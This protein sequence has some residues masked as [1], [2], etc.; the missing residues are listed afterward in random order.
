[1]KAK[2]DQERLRNL[3][4]AT[5]KTQGEIADELGMSRSTFALLCSNRKEYPHSQD[6]DT[7]KNIADFF[8]V[9]PKYLTGESDYMNA[10][11]FISTAEDKMFE[12][13]CIGDM[14]IKLGIVTPLDDKKYMQLSA[15]GDHNSVFIDNP[16]HVDMNEIEYS[17]FTAYLAEQIRS[18]CNNYARISVSH[19]IYGSHDFD[20]YS[21]ITPD[22]LQKADQ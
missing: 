14:L 11:H 9:D 3:W 5:G 15:E 7:I 17:M 13:R 21:D 16:V 18:A 10:A 6:E 19:D 8:L 2:I 22:P 4:K 12:A 20:Q 1:M